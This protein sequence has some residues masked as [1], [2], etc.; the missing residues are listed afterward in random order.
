[1]RCAS[2]G[3]VLAAAVPDEVE[4]LADAELDAQLV[5]DVERGRRRAAHQHVGVDEREVAD[6]DRH[7]LAEPARLAPPRPRARGGGRSARCTASLPRRVSEPSITSSCT[8]ANVC[9]SSS[10]AAASTTHG[11]VGIA[12]GADERAVTERGPEPLAADV[13]ERA[14]RLDRFGERG[15]DRAPA[16]ELGVEQIVDPRLDPGRE[17]HERRGERRLLPPGLGH[18]GTVGRAS[19]ELRQ[20]VR[21]YPAPVPEFLSETW[22]RGARRRAA[23]RRGAWR[24]SAPLVIEQV[25]RDVPGAGRGALPGLGRRATAAMRR[26]SAGAADRAADVRLTTDYATA[27]AIARGSENAQ[28][29]AG[30]RPP[31]ARRRHRRRSCAHADA[32]AA[33]DDA[34]AALRAATTY[35]GATGESP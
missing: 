2:A 28:T 24:R 7:A 32:L 23:A 10:A 5:E 33:L 26:R 15:V 6:E 22:L 31:A 17:G 20:R 12:A 16:R 34:T 13:D 18:G 30:P 27:A 19:P 1:M 4:R 11:I 8:S 9:T 3:S 35:D 14:Q 25:V 21:P 29:R